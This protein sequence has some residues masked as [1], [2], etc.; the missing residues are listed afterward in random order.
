MHFCRSCFFSHMVSFR[1]I[2][3]FLN[4]SCFCFMSNKYYQNLM[5]LSFRC[6]KIS[7]LCKHNFSIDE[8]IRNEI[9]IPK[10]KYFM[11]VFHVSWNAPEPVFHEMLW[12]K[13]F[14]VYPCL[15]TTV[16]SCDQETQ[17]S[18]FSFIKTCIQMFR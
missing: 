18:S 8:N 15:N 14:T 13:Y 2:L 3:L 4:F 9:Y 5:L 7:F 17:I 12:K 1:C 10:Q 16:L 11:K 6:Q